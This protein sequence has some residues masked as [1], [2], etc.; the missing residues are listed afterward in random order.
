[1]LPKSFISFV[2]K[3]QWHNEITSAVGAQARD[4]KKQPVEEEVLRRTSLTS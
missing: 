4:E 1:M 2:A 3:R